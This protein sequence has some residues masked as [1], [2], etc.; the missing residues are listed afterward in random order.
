MT[1]V[2]QLC[3]YPQ[4]KLSL[5]LRE[6]PPHVCVQLLYLL[7]SRRV[8]VSGSDTSFPSSQ[9]AMN[10]IPVV[11][12]SSHRLRT[13]LPAPTSDGSHLT[14]MES[15]LKEA[16]EVQ[17]VPNPPVKKQLVKP[18]MPLKPFRFI[19]AKQ[20][21]LQYLE[22]AVVELNKAAPGTP[23]RKLSRWV[24]VHS[25]SLTFIFF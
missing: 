16:Y 7:R 3:L 13:I 10:L 24:L 15:L 14:L 25:V 23:P 20:P 22:S 4:K 1:I 19:K 5:Q 17:R 12:P 6:L 11:K 2:H 18:V 9:V 21:H 8:R